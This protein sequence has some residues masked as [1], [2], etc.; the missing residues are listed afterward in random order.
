MSEQPGAIDLT[1]DGLPGG[2][3]G[4]GPE[5]ARPQPD[6]TPGGTSGGWVKAGA[7]YQGGREFSY[8]D[9]YYAPDGPSPWKQT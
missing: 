4:V 6:D 3:V 2:N 7:G 5:A 9:G 1:T 8:G